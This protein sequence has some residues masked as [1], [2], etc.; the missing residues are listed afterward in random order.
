MSKI[1][2]RPLVEGD[3][4]AVLAIEELSFP[5]PWARASFVHELQ[6]SHSQLTVA[7]QQGQVV[8]YVCCWYVADEV[9]ILDIAVHPAC[10]RQGVGERLLRHALVHGQQRGALS[11]NLE[12]RHNNLSAI[13]LY[14]KFGFCEVGVRQRYYANGE[15][16]LVMVC[17][18]TDCSSFAGEKT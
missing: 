9:H 17:C 5:S 2:L 8:G 10:R 18:F 3:L 7:E 15:D 11:A 1:I 12:V 14:Q 13:A 16:A 4:D 6:S